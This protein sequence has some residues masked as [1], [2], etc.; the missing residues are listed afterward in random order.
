VLKCERPHSKFE[1]EWHSFFMKCGSLNRFH[2]N[3]LFTIYLIDYLLFTVAWSFNC[4]PG[5]LLFFSNA[6][7][8]FFFY[9]FTVTE[10]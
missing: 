3:R 2:I 5:V 1:V 9:F 10:F 4:V 7:R 8:G 6:G